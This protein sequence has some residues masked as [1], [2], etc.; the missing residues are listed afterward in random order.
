[1]R[2]T[3]FFSNKLH[4]Y[5]DI[6]KFAKYSVVDKESNKVKQLLR[7]RF[8]KWKKIGN[9]GILNNIGPVNVLH[10]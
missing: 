1:M 5:T 2:I 6:I 7:Y 4:E 8:E 10:W 3:V 9:F